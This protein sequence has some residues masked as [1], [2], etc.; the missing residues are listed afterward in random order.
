YARFVPSERTECQC[1]Y[2]IQTRDHI[3]SDCPILEP[4]HHH[5]RAV[6]RNISTPFI[7]GTQAGLNALT[8]FIKASRA[9]AKAPPRDRPLDQPHETQDPL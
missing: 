3:L 9:F 6:S 1:G 4:H 7:L 2:S 8:R 5:L